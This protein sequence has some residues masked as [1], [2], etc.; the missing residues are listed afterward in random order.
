MTDDLFHQQAIAIKTNAYAAYSN[1]KV[2]AVIEDEHGAHHLGVNV[3][4]AAYPLGSCAE[5]A[6]IAAM[7]QAGGRRIK[8]IAI[9]GSDHTICT[10][11]GGCRQRIAEFSDDDTRIHCLN[12]DG[13]LNE[14]FTPYSLL[15]HG[16]TLKA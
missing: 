4:N 8:R 6:A 2:G 16:F 10:P 3:E 13:S 12:D 11:C 7:V 9:S 1:F 14:I 15:P 5:A